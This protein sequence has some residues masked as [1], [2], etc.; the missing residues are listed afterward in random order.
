MLKNYFYWL[1][2]FLFGCLSQ[3]AYQWLPYGVNDEHISTLMYAAR[4][5]DIALM[6]SALNQGDDINAIS[7]SGMTALH[8]AIG[9]DQTEAAGY[10]ITHGAQVH[11]LDQWENTPLS[12]ARGRNLDPVVRALEEKIL[13]STIDGRTVIDSN[14]HFIILVASFNNARWYR[15]N[16]D[17][18][19]MQKYRKYTVIYMDDVSTDGTFNL[20][21]SYCAQKS[22]ASNIILL[23]NKKK[24]FCLGNYIWA[25]KRFCP[26]DAILITLD[27]DDWFAGNDVLAYLNEVYKNPAI[28]LTY[29]ESV[30]YPAYV[31]TPHCRPISARLFD[32]KE[33]LRRKCAQRVFWPVHHCRSFYGWLFMLI[34]KKDFIDANG[35]YF[36][37]AEDVAYM[38]PM[39]EMAGAA[40][41]KYISKVL[42]VY[43]RANP[44]VTSRTRGTDAVE[45]KFLQIC[46]K[47]PYDM[48]SVRPGDM[49]AQ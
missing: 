20:V 46:R 4:R 11:I 45:N 25:I 39:L 35:R 49:T 10:L 23:K 40:H 31:K 37:F 48:L 42:Y 6:A 22:D 17:S 8:Y 19:F 5:G 47:A 29:G 27:G 30:T 43:N 14:K 24:K 33:A 41:H 26:R 36:T 34:D 21:R 7:K 3:C 2:I 16:L 44:L 18:I 15:N 12:M 1:S 9:F 38:L 28:W 13:S 32:Q